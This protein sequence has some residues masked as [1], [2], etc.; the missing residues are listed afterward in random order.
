MARPLRLDV[1][2]AVYHVTARGNERRAIFRDDEDRHDYL[3]RLAFYRE[4][5]GFRLL[6][7][8][9]MT[10]HIHLAIRRGASAL[11]RVMASLHSSYT[12]SFNRRHRRVGHLFQGRYKSFLVQEDR[13][14]QALIRYIH[15]NPVRAGIVGK[16]ADYPWSS[17]RFFR[18][19]QPPSWLDVDD[20]LASFG[21]TRRSALR[22]YLALVDGTTP[23]DS[24]YEAIRA[25]DQ[26]VKGDEL[27]ALTRFEQVGELTPPL[28]GLS[29]DRV[30]DAV[31]RVTGVPLEDLLGSTKRGAVSTA[32]HLAAYVAF[33]AGGISRRR[34]ARRFHLD[35][36]SLARPLSRLESRLKSDTKLRERVEGLIQDL[37]V[38]GFADLA[39]LATASRARASDSEAEK[40]SKQD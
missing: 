39:S 21:P 35:D 11:S 12:Q 6:A 4:K 13:Y 30:I 28:R 18:C 26:V 5:F 38:A 15:Q 34:M 25:V 32:R 29:E 24:E 14:L 17:D 16:A 23:A 33:R 40:A 22:R 27:F 1:P 36:S 37:R 9:L 20:V 19:E 2:G 31:S 7:Y 8:C 10:N 3:S